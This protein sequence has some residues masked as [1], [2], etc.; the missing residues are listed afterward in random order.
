MKKTKGRIIWPTL[1]ALSAFFSGLMTWMAPYNA[2]AAAQTIAI[3]IILWCCTAFCI[4]MTVIRI[5][6]KRKETH[7]HTKYSQA[8][9]A[10]VTAATG[11][12]Y[13]Q[14]GYSPPMQN[15]SNY[16]AANQS[17]LQN[18]SVPDYTAPNTITCEGF[19]NAMQVMGVF[20]I[21]GRGWFAKGHIN[22]GEFSVGD[23]V[24]IIRKNGS[25]CDTKI[26]EIRAQQQ[27]PT[28]V[29]QGDN[30]TFMLSCITQADIERGDII[31]KGT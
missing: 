12:G 1:A 9:N 24:T 27:M 29:R 2:N 19:P 16:S 3:L 31:R 4:L 18:Q 26:E 28:T 15:I 22:E 13:P 8:L 7:P 23:P 6:R 21:Y 25:T 20:Q 5:F 11:A 30:A 14:S 10:G 17:T